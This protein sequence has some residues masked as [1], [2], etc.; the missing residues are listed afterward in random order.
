MHRHVLICVD[1]DCDRKLLER[2]RRAIDAAGPRATAAKSKVK[3]FGIRPVTV[4][5]SRG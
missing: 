1:D 2:F 5:C 3:C 4:D